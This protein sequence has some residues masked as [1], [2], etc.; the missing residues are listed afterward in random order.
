MTQYAPS[1]SSSHRSGHPP[2]R[3]TGSVRTNAKM[4]CATGNTR[5]ER[6]TSHLPCTL[7]IGIRRVATIAPV[8]AA[9]ARTDVTPN[10][11]RL[12]RT[13]GTEPMSV[14]E[15]SPLRSMITFSLRGIILWLPSD[16]S[17]GSPYFRMSFG[18]KQRSTRWHSIR[19]S[20]RVEF[21][22]NALSQECRRFKLKTEGADANPRFG[23]SERQCSKIVWSIFLPDATGASGAPPNC[24]VP[25]YFG[26]G[27]TE[28]CFRPRQPP[29]FASLRMGHPHP[30]P[31][32]SVRCAAVAC[33][34]ASHGY[35]G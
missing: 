33:G 2:S 10:D 22:T 27:E 11:N 24:E 3:V 29:P 30:L 13:R 18:S 7:G 25:M 16:C 19:D 6:P 8:I 12:P 15:T 28:A 35:I 14:P 9:E 21:L 20:L 17:I 31:W 5:K 32:D 4:A 26:R 23:R 1:V 34:R